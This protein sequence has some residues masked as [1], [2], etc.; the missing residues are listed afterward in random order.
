MKCLFSP[1]LASK[2]LLPSH[3]IV[4]G[5]GKITF[6]IRLNTDTTRAVIHRH[7]VS[8]LPLSLLDFRKVLNKFTIDSSE[9]TCTVCFRHS[10]AVKSPVKSHMIDNLGRRSGTTMAFIYTN[11]HMDTIQCK[12]QSH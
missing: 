12:S 10:C 8:N 11:Q 9:T 6:I 4:P 3:D 2:S 5:L 1:K 7:S